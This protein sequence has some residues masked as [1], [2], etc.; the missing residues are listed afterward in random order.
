[1]GENY[2][3]L[4]LTTTDVTSSTAINVSLKVPNSKVIKL[5]QLRGIFA[6]TYSG[7]FKFTLVKNNTALNQTFET[8]IN[9]DNI[10]QELNL[11]CQNGDSIQIQTST[12]APNGTHSFELFFGNDGH[13]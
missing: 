1:M 11:Y 2:Y 4:P 12:A 13:T 8:N 3:A 10:Y 9:A 5:L 6:S 7:T